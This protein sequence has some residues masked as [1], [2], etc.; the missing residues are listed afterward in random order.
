MAR[1]LINIDVDDLARAEAFYTAAFGLRAGRRFGAGGVELL[2]AE[3]PL[4]LLAR[5]AGSAPH[6]GAAAARDYGRHWTPL[7]LDF[8]VDD[9]DAAMRD[10]LAAGALA[11]G[12]V[13]AS[14][15]G[16]IATFADPWGHGFCLIEFSARGYDAVADA[17]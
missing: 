6:H 7:H 10:V 12:E 4:F 14:T 3:A 11:E 16:R 1:V 13:R 2:G 17:G 8:A 15:W 5:P 9:L